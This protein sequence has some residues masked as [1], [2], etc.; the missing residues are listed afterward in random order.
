MTNLFWYTNEEGENVMENY[1]GDFNAACRIASKWADE[2][3]EC[4]YVNCDED[5]VGVV[6]PLA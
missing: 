3:N 5:I 4:C 1:Y 6:W 2:H